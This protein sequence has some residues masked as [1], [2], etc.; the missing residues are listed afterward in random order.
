[1]RRRM[2]DFQGGT[3]RSFVSGYSSM[4][5]WEGEH[6]ALCGES[7]HK[8]TSE[9]IDMISPSDTYNRRPS[10]DEMSENRSLAKV[11]INMSIQDYK[12]S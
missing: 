11:S 8:S 5:H 12:C 4:S 7:M 6:R 9:K 1:M 2:F 10:M 3:K